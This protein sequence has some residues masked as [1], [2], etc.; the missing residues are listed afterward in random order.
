M[1][2][3][4]KIFGIIFLVLIMF[5]IT[6]CKNPHKD[7]KVSIKDI[8]WE[9]KTGVVYGEKWAVVCFTNNSKYNICEIEIDL[10]P[11]KSFKG[12]KLEE[13]YEYFQ[14]EYDETDE[15]MKYLKEYGELRIECDYYGRYNDDKPIE[16]GTTIYNERISYY[17]YLYAHNLDWED[18][19][20]PYIA[21]IVY[22][23]DGKI[24]TVYYDYEANEYTHDS[25]VETLDD[26]L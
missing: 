26:Y 16:P 9:L 20:E 17:G 1:N 7:E 10:R 12:S 23:D 15:D 24:Y 4:F 2:K 21:T 8:E 5:T 25:E 11:Q 18:Y 14:V 19:F 13:F 6:A 3:K 22:E